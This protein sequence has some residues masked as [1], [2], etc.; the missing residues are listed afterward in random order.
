MNKVQQ[1]ILVI[2]FLVYSL[3]PV[4]S[5]KIDVT[6]MTAYEKYSPQESQSNAQ[7]FLTH[8]LKNIHEGNLG[9]DISFPITKDELKSKFGISEDEYFPLNRNINYFERNGYRYMFSKYKGTEHLVVIQTQFESLTKEQIFSIFG[10]KT[11]GDHKKR[12]EITYKVG[13]F[14][15]MFLNTDPDN[16]ID[17]NA[18]MLSS[19]TPFDRT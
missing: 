9:S 13:N 1:I 17:Y 10:K 19:R 6:S 11:Y 18:I 2:G 14:M 12:F 16:R 5:N 4:F 7:E 3:T 8:I 15:V